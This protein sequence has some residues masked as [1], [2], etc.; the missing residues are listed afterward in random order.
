MT[1]PRG[2]RISDNHV[3]P[4]YPHPDPWDGQDPLGVSSMERT[5]T[6]LS[7][8]ERAA[9]YAGFDRLS[10]DGAPLVRPPRLRRR[11]YGR[12][13]LIG[14]LIGALLAGAAWYRA[15]GAEPISGVAITVDGDTIKIG[16]TRIRLFG[17]DAPERQQTCADGHGSPY[18]CGTAATNA[19]RAMLARDPSV[20]CQPKN[21]DH[22]G[23]MVAVCWNSGGNLGARMVALGQAI[24]VPRYSGGAYRDQQDAARAEHLGMWAGTFQQPEQ[25]RRE[26]GR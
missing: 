11:R 19:M 18:A 21:I 22:Y 24:D 3:I 6:R 20:T 2:T 1:I 13:A 17:I 7:D 12:A 8:R 15:Y 14:G 16:T 25:W 10:L 4:L 9:G 23:R 5:V 26:N